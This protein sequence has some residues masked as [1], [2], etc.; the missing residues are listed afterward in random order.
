MPTSSNP[1]TARRLLESFHCVLNAV[2]HDPEQPITTLPIV[3]PTDQ[4]LLERWSDTPAEYARESTIHRQ[5]EAAAAR[6]PSAVAV[7]GESGLLTYAELDARSNRLAARLRREGVRKGELVGLCLERTI[8]A[9]V[10]ELAVLKAGAGY[11]PLDPAYPASRLGF[12]LQDAR[13]RVVLTHAEPPA[14][15]CPQARP[16]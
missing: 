11:L 6:T 7:T 13:V 3:G 4:A 15:G 10:A 2:S 1:E 12:M 9:I 16:G 5:F 8:E 14:V